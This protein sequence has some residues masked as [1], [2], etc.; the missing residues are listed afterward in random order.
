MKI[1][2]LIA[3]SRRHYRRHHL[4]FAACLALVSAVMTGALLVGDAVRESL[5]ARV[6]D[7]MGRIGSVLMTEDRVFEGDLASRLQAVGVAAPI[8]AVEGVVVDPAS[9]LEAPGALILGVDERFWQLSPGGTAPVGFE[10]SG[11]FANATAMAMLGNP[12]LPSEVVVRMTKPGQLQRDIAAA[13]TSA[14]RASDRVSLQ[15][16]LTRAT[17]G[18]FG[19]T[20]DPAT[21]PVLILPLSRLQEILG[22]SHQ[23]NLLL[24]DRT[25]TAQWQKALRTEW[26]LADA[27]LKLQSL[28]DGRTELTTGAVFLSPKILAAAESLPFPKQNIYGYFVNEIQGSDDSAPYCVVAGLSEPL[29][30]PLPDQLSPDGVVINRWLADRIEVAPGDSMVW[31][32][33]RLGERRALTE[34]TVTL[35]VQAVVPM[36]GAAADRTLMPDFPGLAD[37]ES[38]YD[39]D[40]GLPVDLDLIQPA[41]EAYWQEHQGTPKAFLTYATA[42]RLFDNPFGSGT[43]VRFEAEPGEVAKA[44]RK[45]L[46]A[47]EVGLAFRDVRT[48][49]E[50]ATRE[51]LDFGQLFA[52]MS[53]FLVTA[54]ACLAGLVVS[55]VLEARMREVGM[56]RAMGFEFQT[57]RQ[58]WLREFG[59]VAL[60]GTVVGVPLGVGFNLAILAGLNRIWQGATG[61]LRVEF[62]WSLVSLLTAPLL[63]LAVALLVVWLRFQARGRTSIISL[64]TGTSPETRARF[65]GWLWPAIA[66]IAA[67]GLLLASA[68]A[69]RQLQA[70]LFF[71]AGAALLASWLLLMRTIWRRPP[72]SGAH[73]AGTLW[74][75]WRQARRRPGRSLAVVTLLALATFLVVSVGVNR[76]S[77]PTDSNDRYS[78]TGGFGWLAPLSVPLTFNPNDPAAL[79]EFGMLEE[80]IEALHLTGLRERSGDDASCLNLAR[81]QEPRVLGVPLEAMK[82]RFRFLDAQAWDG[83]EALAADLPGNHIPA[84]VDASTLQWGLGKSLGD[85]ITITAADGLPVTLEIVAVLEDSIFQGSVLIS[86]ENFSEAF[87]DQGGYRW[88]LGTWMPE[89]ATTTRK[90]VGQLFRDYGPAIVSTQA[91]LAQFLEVQNTYLAIFEWLG[92]LGLLLGAVG[93]GLVTLRNLLER[94]EEFWLL[95]ALGFPQS[96]QRS[97]A[98]VEHAI[99]AGIGIL[100]GGVAG[101]LPLIAGQ[102]SD[103]PT[104]SPGLLGLLLLL[105]AAAASLAIALAVKMSFQSGGRFDPNGS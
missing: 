1:R 85:T 102:L 6:E 63:T 56:M 24:T 26:S 91:R 49:A 18:Q 22:L 30:S 57:I 19:L 28:D 16:E 84:A 83:W 64:L 27:G 60:A 72:R 70:S 95:Q 90:L 25:A 52:S 9:R 39:W 98:F 96:Q 41:D 101:Y 66:T 13:Q 21:Q 48:P 4:A 81:A 33:Y 58:I 75:G 65:V 45:H 87:P 46:S 7:R 29:P 100:G 103:L 31:T 93:L 17:F 50:I 62:G 79:E 40:P 44:L 76:K 88:L 53:F 23:A 37:T 78:G 74:L 11:A 20:T 51:G 54:A 47:S 86:E 34:E 68:F 43:A 99:L 89:G 15:G 3:R 61:G 35:Q 82:N 38:C 55:L 59:G 8:L 92:G 104:G 97:L 32:Y 42:Q 73:R 77:P 2:G 10:T 80:E 12:I 105:V 67:V 69:D 94:R 5:A 14:F 71:G 36:E